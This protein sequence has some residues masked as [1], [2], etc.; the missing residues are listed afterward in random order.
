MAEPTNWPPIAIVTPVFNSARYLEATIQSV[1][2]QGYPNLQYV[3]ADGGSTDGTLEII[4]KYEPHLHTWFSEPD[5]GMY[6][7][8]NKGFA[9]TTHPICCTCARYSPWGAFFRLFPKWNGSPD[10]RRS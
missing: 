10:G 5:R 9:R 1:I 6:D 4:R 2:S 3:I 8:L 7:A